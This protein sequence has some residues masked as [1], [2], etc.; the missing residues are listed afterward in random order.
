MPAGVAVSDLLRIIE[1]YH[2]LFSRE[3]GLRLQGMR[4]GVER[5]GLGFGERGNRELGH[6]HN[7]RARLLPKWDGEGFGVGK[8]WEQYFGMSYILSLLVGF[9]Y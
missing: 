1:N 6:D 8:F 4:G 3:K 5:G 7:G 2:S 9:A